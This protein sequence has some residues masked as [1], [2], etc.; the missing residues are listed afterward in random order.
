MPFAIITQPT[1]QVPSSASQFRYLLWDPFVPG[2]HGV[3]QLTS[4]CGHQPSEEHPARLQFTIHRSMRSMRS[5]SVRPLPPFH[6]S[7]Q[8]H[9]STLSPLPRAGRHHLT[10]QA[11]SP[12]RRLVNCFGCGLCYYCLCRD[13]NRDNQ[14]ST[15]TKRNQRKQRT[16]EPRVGLP[17]NPVWAVRGSSQ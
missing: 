6:P 15:G 13:R 11:V 1:C 16:L 10:A 12:A 4:L 5:T 9:Y 7:H 8:P 14:R 3:L 17:W 2:H